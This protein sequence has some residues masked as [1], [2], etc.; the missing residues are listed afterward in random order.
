MNAIRSKGS[1]RQKAEHQFEPGTL[2][3]F[4]ASNFFSADYEAVADDGSAAAYFA[5][6]HLGSA[7][8]F[9]HEGSGLHRGYRRL[10]HFRTDHVDD[11]LV[12][13]PLSG[14]TTMQQ[15]GTQV[16]VKTGEFI[17]S[18]TA[19]PMVVTSESENRL[20]KFQTYH[21]RVSGSLLRARAPLIDGYCHIPIKIAPGAGEIMSSMFAMAFHNG[22]ALT[23]R[24]SRVLGAMLIDAV[25]NATC[26]V[27]ELEH[28]QPD[29]RQS[30]YA[31]I[32]EKAVHFIECNMS[33]PALDPVLIAEHCE[34]SVRYLHAAF[35]SAQRT[36]GTMIKEMRLEHCHIEL[37]SP[38]LRNRSVFEI[39]LRWGFNDPAYFS[40]AYK[41]KFGKTPRESRGAKK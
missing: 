4:L 41:A 6:V 5:G 15:M 36:I 39:A 7:D 20:S 12:S 21:V 31:R 13:L 17:L 30:S 14:R 18:P 34:V 35:A 2:K 9:R 25:A 29:Q 3:T 37:Q 11:F 28:L 10:Q 23:E 26:D 19:I 33:N 8:V 32:R 40:R 22:P 38:E 27:P 1:P 16:E 24:Q